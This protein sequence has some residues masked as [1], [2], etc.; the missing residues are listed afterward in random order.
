MASGPSPLS[1][2]FGLVHC[3]CLDHQEI[4]R[5]G[6]KPEPWHWTPWKYAEGGRFDGRWDDPAGIWRTLYLGSS[7]LACYL[8]VL[9]PF[10]PDPEVAA[11]IAEIAGED[12]DDEPVAPG[13]LAYSWCDARLICSARLSGCF[14]LP[15]HQET[16]STLRKRKYFLQLA[17]LC[18][19]SDLDAA[20]IRDAKRE[21]TQAISAWIYTQTGTGGELADGIEYQSRHGDYLP[22]WAVYERDAGYDSPPQITDHDAQLIAADNP[23]LLEAMS[24]HNIDWEA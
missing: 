21:L 8:E 22:L 15:G 3:A 23:F 6:Y 19:C 17:K 16:L 9:A 1:T 18:G 20:A 10:R 7:E 2:P 5:V 13:E 4:H 14:A 11:E 12:D 24:L